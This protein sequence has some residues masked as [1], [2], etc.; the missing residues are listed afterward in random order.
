MRSS[1]W[2][3]SYSKKWLSLVIRYLFPWIGTLPIGSITVP[4]LL[5]TLRK[6]KAKGIFSTVQDLRESASHLTGALK[7]PIV[8]HH[9]AT[10][11][12][13]QVG[14]LLRAIDGYDGQPATR[15]ALQLSALLYQRPG[16]I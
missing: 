13:V 9:A 16:N 5:A 3:P 8:T 4:F 2:S 15:A 6:A 14:G 10:V 1:A 12:P 7:K 11:D